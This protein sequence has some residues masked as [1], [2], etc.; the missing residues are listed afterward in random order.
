MTKKVKR[1]IIEWVVFIVLIGGLYLTG[2]HTTVIGTLQR[3]ILSTGLITA[4]RETDNLKT[5]DYNLKLKDAN[6]DMLDLN[7]LQGKTIFMNYWA[8]WCPPC[9]AEMPDINN[10]Y[11]DVGQDV[12]FLMISLDDDPQKALDFVERKKY[13]FPIYYLDS[14]RPQVFVSQSIPTTYVISPE[15]KIVVENKGMAKYNTESFKKMLANL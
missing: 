15:G 6:G 4:D 7:E 14:R 11:R 13:D 1:E 9:I 2:Y 12:V 3:I 10:L 8:T 5:A